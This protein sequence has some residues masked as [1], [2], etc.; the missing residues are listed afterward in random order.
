MELKTNEYWGKR[1]GYISKLGE[2]L[3]NI[4]RGSKNAISDNR[5]PTGYK[6]RRLGTI[7]RNRKLKR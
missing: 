4:R 5:G 3:F 1:S 7:Y 6:L 2:R